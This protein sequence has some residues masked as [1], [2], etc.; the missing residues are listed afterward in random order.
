MHPVLQP[1]HELLEMRDPS[2]KRTEMIPLGTDSRCRGWFVS[3]L[4]RATNPA[5]PGD[6]SLTLAHV[7]RRPGRFGCGATGG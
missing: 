7:H 1:L 4:G 5:D 3:R 6:Q 2:L